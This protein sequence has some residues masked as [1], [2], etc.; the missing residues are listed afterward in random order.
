MWRSCLYRPAPWTQLPSPQSPEP[1][2]E[3]LLSNFTDFPLCSGPRSCS[4][5][6]AC[7]THSPTPT[8]ARRPGKW[9]SH[10]FCPPNSECG[11]L[12]TLEIDEEENGHHT[13]WDAK[14]I[15]AECSRK[16]RVPVSLLGD[17][18]ESSMSA[19]PLRCHGELTGQTGSVH[20]R[21]PTCSQDALGI[22]QKW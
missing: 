3:P 2:L 9:L 6:A 21:A 5:M 22:G 19:I 12:D 15:F 17:R 16:S 20:V 13:P 18:F 7:A 4:D 8:E 11:V 1:P 10:S 14:G